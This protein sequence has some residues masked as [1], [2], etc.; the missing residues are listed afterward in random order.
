MGCSSVSAL[1]WGAMGDGWMDGAREKDG[2][3]ETG[4]RDSHNG[5]SEQ[6]CLVWH[7]LEGGNLNCIVAVI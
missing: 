4:R 2:N 1:P 6:S 3:D 7:D 5:V